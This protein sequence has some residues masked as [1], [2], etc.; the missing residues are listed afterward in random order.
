[1]KSWIGAF[2]LNQF[3]TSSL[4]AFTANNEQQL[5]V[6]FVFA[7]DICSEQQNEH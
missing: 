7:L 1:M 6:S 5:G 2:T 3:M 4:F